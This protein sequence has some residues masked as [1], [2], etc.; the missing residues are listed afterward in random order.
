MG[1]LENKIAVVT[2]G[3][4]ELGMAI[5]KALAVEGA[6]LALLDFSDSAELQGIAAEIGQMGRK[7]L[8]RS[9]NL[10]DPLTV[11]PLIQEA[12]R[13]LGP[14]TILVNNGPGTLGTPGRAEEVTE[15]Q[16]DMVIARNLTAA[17]LCAQAVLP[18]METAGS[19]SIVNISSSAARGYSDFSGPQYVAAKMGLIGLARHLAREFGPKGIRAN[20]LAQGFTQTQEA[21][22]RWSTKT[23]KEK[24]ALLRHIH[25]RRRATPAEHARVVVFLA[26]DDSSYVTGATIDVSGG[27]FTL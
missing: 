13:R 19:G 4:G 1:R 6:H 17:F 18:F 15:A 7:A 2:G 9:G 8:A 16:W 11:Q 27:M 22:T 23:E 21:E 10:A 5:A 24:D 14:P 25:L 3:G 20:A 26:S 12:A